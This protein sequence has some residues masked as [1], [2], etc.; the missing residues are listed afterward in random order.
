MRR[1]QRAVADFEGK[2]GQVPRD[3][4]SLGPQS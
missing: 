1:I 3:A 2:K 4:G